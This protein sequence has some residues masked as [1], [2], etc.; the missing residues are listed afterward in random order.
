MMKIKIP[1]NPTEL[2]SL[3]GFTGFF[4]KF[5]PNYTKIIMPLLEKLK[6]NKDFEIREVER[7]CIEKLG[8]EI[9]NAKAL[10]LPVMQ[11]KFYLYADASYDTIGGALKQIRNGEE[12]VVFWVSRKL[13]QAELNYTVTEKECLAIVWCI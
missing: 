12:R 9:R 13:L 5:I 2:K 1:Q 10:I 3:L 11:D 8:K 7:K 4:K 6:K